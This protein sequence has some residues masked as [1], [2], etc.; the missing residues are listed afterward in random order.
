MCTQ[1]HTD[2]H[3]FTPLAWAPV[4]YTMRFALRGRVRLETQHKVLI[5]ATLL[6]LS[7]A[8]LVMFS[9]STT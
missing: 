7:H 4:M 2:W 5:G 1:A 8:G 3:K 6:A 9:D